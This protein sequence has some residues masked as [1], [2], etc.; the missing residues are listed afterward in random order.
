MLL[1]SLPACKCALNVARRRL[2]LAAV[3]EGLVPLQQFVGQCPVSVRR[4]PENPRL[5][6]TYYLF[7]YLSI[8]SAPDLFS[9]VVDLVDSRCRLAGP[10]GNDLKILSL[11]LVLERMK[12]APGDKHDRPFLDFVFDVIEIENRLAVQDD[13]D[14][15]MSLMDAARRGEATFESSVIDLQSF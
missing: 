5:L 4:A 13:I 8:R 12:C 15:I 6:P 9:Q 7:V 3:P 10:D 14:L 11:A 2:R 1:Y